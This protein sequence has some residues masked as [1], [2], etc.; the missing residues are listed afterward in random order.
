M[1]D[2][3]WCV[4]R[5]FMSRSQYLAEPL[6]YVTAPYQ[7]TA[8]YGSLTSASAIAR[9]PDPLP[10]LVDHH[11]EQLAGAR[12]LRA[13]VAALHEATRLPTALHHVLD[14][15]MTL[16]SAEF[17]NVQIVDPRDGSLVLVAQSGLSPG[18]LEH[19]AL[20]RDDGSVCGR[21]AVNGTQTV[22]GDV[23]EEPLLE[24]HWAVFRAAGIRAVQSTP[25]V[26]GDGRLIGVV[27]THTS[28]ARERSERDLH[29]MRIYGRFV[30]DTLARLL[31]KVPPS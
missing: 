13:A 4:V 17:A 2:D 10:G 30:G 9:T 5:V 26:D 29:L 11:G 22:V 1:T 28:W 25:V 12:T 20:V 3:R 27:S 19:F 24:P 18:F 6:H 21:A 8:P 15:S 7:A 23:R 14:D 31:P 16:M